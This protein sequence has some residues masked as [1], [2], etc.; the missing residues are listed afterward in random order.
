MSHPE[1]IYLAGPMTG[2][3]DHNFPAFRAA[4]KRLQQAGWEVINPADNFGGCT[5]LPRSSYLR[6]DVAL[7]LQCDAMAMLPGWHDSRGAK[8][9]Y[10]LG[11]ELGMPIID[12]ATFQPL[13]DAP[14]PTVRLRDGITPRSDDSFPS[15]TAQ[16]GI[17]ADYRNFRSPETRQVACNQMRGICP[18]GTS[19]LD[20]VLEIREA[21]VDRL[22]DDLSI[23]LN[24]LKY[25]AQ[26]F[27][28]SSSGA[29][30]SLVSHDVVDEVETDGRDQAHDLTALGQRP[31]LGRIVSEWRTVDQVVE[32]HIGVEED[33]VVHRRPLSRIAASYSSR[34]LFL[35]DTLANPRNRRVIGAVFRRDS[36]GRVMVSMYWLNIADTLVP[37]SSASCLAF[38]ITSWSAL[39][40]SLGMAGLLYVQSICDYTYR[41]N[42][43]QDSVSPQEAA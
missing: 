42:P 29:L 27:D 32:Q 21:R 11:R 8:L 12:I 19:V 1:R 33:P 4:A 34:S 37:R 16:V 18:D 2:L 6:A 28:R 38:S 3:P 26:A 22:V 40:V 20:R 5:N 41:A 35:L 24:G 43:R 30:V 23:H 39:R 10:L 13:A 14:A 25:I 7:L 31:K 36:R 15:P 17:R 9:E